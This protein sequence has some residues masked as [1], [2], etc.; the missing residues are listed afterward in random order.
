MFVDFQMDIFEEEKSDLLL[1]P[2]YLIFIVIVKGVSE[3]SVLHQNLH[4][5]TV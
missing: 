5:I 2:C 3:K 1:L 4:L